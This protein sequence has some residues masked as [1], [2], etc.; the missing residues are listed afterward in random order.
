MKIKNIR[1]KL[2]IACLAMGIIPLA[3]MGILSYQQS[4]AAL[5]ASHGATLALF[6]NTTMDKIERLYFEREGDL[7]VIV[8]ENRALGSPQEIQEM[9]NF[10]MKSYGFYDLMIVADLD[11]KI[12]AANTVT[13]EGKALDTSKLI[14][15][16]V[17]AE[18]WFKRCTDGKLPRGDNYTV[19]LSVD[20][21][22]AEV[23]HSRGLCVNLSSPVYDPSGKLVR[24][25]SNRV[26]WERTVGLIMKEV[27]KEGKECGITIDPQMISKDAM[28][29]Y[30]EDASRILTLNYSNS[31]KKTVDELKAGHNGYLEEVS[32]TTG[33][34]SLY[35]LYPY[36]DRSP[37]V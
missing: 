23:T 19:D 13:G 36:N 7:Q 2:I 24:V 20:K 6:A 25:W 29:I 3:I 10:F 31:G 14:G 1:T 21:M 9:S 15:Q 5:E 27:K 4:R 12:I 11:G 16:S 34:L 32:H 22:L 30:D 26:S 18:E 17:K 37:V 33:L 35:G 8:N 28:V